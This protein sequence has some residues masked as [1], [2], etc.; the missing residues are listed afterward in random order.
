MLKPCRERVLPFDFAE[1]SS[2]DVAQDRPF[3]LA[4]D[5]PNPNLTPVKVFAN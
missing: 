1:V 4:Q 3:D 5:R 2:F